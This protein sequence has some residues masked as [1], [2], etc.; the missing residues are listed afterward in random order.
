[1]SNQL[2]TLL[3]K[4][5]YC[6]CVILLENYLNGISQ[7]RNFGNN[8]EKTCKSIYTMVLWGYG[9]KQTCI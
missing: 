6:S 5:E 3:N 1:M 2:V 9:L 4:T 8:S 7:D